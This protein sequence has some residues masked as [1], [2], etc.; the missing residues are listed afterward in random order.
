MAELEQLQ[1]RLD[2]E[3]LARKSAEEIAEEK[4]RQLFENNQELS[5]LG[6]SIKKRSIE[7]QE[8]LGYLT[9]IID[10]MADGL[11][12]VDPFN[13]IKL[14]NQSF[15][16]MF[17]LKGKEIVNQSC[18]SVFDAHL[19][20]LIEKS[21]TQDYT[22]SIKLD[23]N[24]PE[25]KTGRAV[26]SP[27]FSEASNENEES[28][29][30]G[31]VIIIRDFTKEKEIDRVKTEFISNV[32][33]ELRTP[34]TSILGFTKIMKKKLVSTLLPVLKKESSPKVQKATNQIQTNLNIIISEGE[35]LT[36]LINGVLDIAKMEA[37]KIDWRMSYLSIPGIIQRV[38]AA[39][40]SLFEDG[41]VKF[42]IDIEDGLP[43]VKADEDRIIQVLI[44]LISNANK[45]TDQGSVI[46]KVIKK[47]NEVVI[48]IIDTGVGITEEEIGQVFDKFK[49]VGDTLTD[50][51]KGTGLGL[52]ICKQIVEHHGGRIWVKSVI[53]KGSEFSFTLPIKE[54]SD[55]SIESSREAEMTALL[56]QLRGQDK[57][58][59]LLE[60]GVIKTVLIVDDEPNIREYLR[61][62]LEGAGYSV[63][64]AKNGLE[65]VSVAKNIMPDL[66]ILDVMMPMMNGFDAA[67]VLKNDPQT[68][69]IPIVIL[70]I[71]EDL[72]R[73]YKIGVNRY[74][75][76]PI[77]ADVL[78]NEVANLV[79][80]KD[81]K[82]AILLVSQDPQTTETLTMALQ[83]DE[84]IIVKI[85]DRDNCIENAKETQPT[86]IIFD[87]SI[88]G[89]EE[90]EKALR[91]E[92][93]LEDISF[94]LLGED[95]DL[96]AL[97]LPLTEA[98]NT[99]Q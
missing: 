96:N 21:N 19:L 12:V 89:Y 55:T 87:S 74:L 16:E 88:S 72:E 4:T 63:R 5:R 49:Q 91:K 41:N 62:E 29:Y 22:E 31:V 50:K 26:A 65:A 82:K 34:L 7:L 43:K 23:I 38:A 6:E 42:L 92:K 73:G 84:N 70:S 24:M 47:N 79:S 28:L 45:F 8:T 44:N 80:Q 57:T 85:C 69:N 46:C 39:T 95:Q 68:M 58:D 83:S 51:P 13:Q 11:L 75:K 14:V 94:I 78:L 77:E 59:S 99:K 66:V 97:K 35:R 10:N 67:A 37:G 86:T 30:I 15:V 27:I 61:Q 9:A 25:N 90:I 53:G 52:P 3:K 17:D 56:C 20:A 54:I 76:K 48:S 1:R 36:N 40:K 71:V 81:K 32:S 98:K 60:E 2:R 93:D 18:S 33:H 64:E